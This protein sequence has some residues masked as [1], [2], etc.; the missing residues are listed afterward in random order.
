MSTNINNV[1][2]F[3]DNLMA[4]LSHGRKNFQFNAEYA[5]FFLKNR[6]YTTPGG[7]QRLK[8]GSVFSVGENA[9]IEPYAMFYQGTFMHTMGAFSSSNSVLPINTIIGR[10]S[11]IAANV[12]R[13]WG[14]HPTDRF[15]TS[16]LT[17]DQNVAAFNDYL[18]DSDA[19]FVRKSHGIKNGS[20]III[21]N[22][23]WIGQD[24]RFASTGITVGDG[25]IVAGGSYV[26]KDVPPYA[27]VGGVPAKFIKYRFPPHIVQK[28]MNL[29]WWKYAYG[30][31]SNAI[32]A[33]E[34]IE[35][36]I[37]KIEGLVA[38]GLIDLY[39]PSP[40]SVANFENV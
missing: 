32:N 20:P 16:M 6:I 9:V 3:S 17:Y 40:V 7:G 19:S 26:T 11:S 15:T 36:F 38:S 37:E 8:N 25:A 4:T 29:K 13:T 12:S 39:S 28:L 18:I 22:D 24:V 10:Y 35:I 2:F 27:V 33:D 23:V 34:K 1:E 31:F 14:N 21:G 5:D 30:D